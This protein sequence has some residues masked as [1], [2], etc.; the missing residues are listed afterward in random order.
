MTVARVSAV[1]VEVLR[2]NTAPVARVSAIDAEV[3]R[4][5]L[6]TRARVSA[7]AVEVLRL[8]LPGPSLVPNMLLMF[9]DDGRPPC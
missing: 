6:A 2:L 9:D 7:L 5:N 3:L 8:Q 1:A 4:L